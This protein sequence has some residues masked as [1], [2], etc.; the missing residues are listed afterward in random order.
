[1]ALLKHF[2]CLD[3]KYLVYNLVRRNLKIK[4]R[5]SWLG[6]L[7][8]LIPPAFSAIIYHFIFTEVMKVKMDHYL[9]FVIAGIVP[10]GVFTVCLQAGLESIPLNQNLINKVPLPVQ[11][12]PFTEALYGWIT[13]IASIPVIFVVAYVDG[14][15]PGPTWLALLP[16]WGLFFVISYSL[17]LIL[18]ILIVYL[19]DL[20][21]VLSLTLQVWFYATPILYSKEMV[22]ERFQWIITL[23]PLGALFTSFHEVLV[24]HRWPS[25]ELLGN[26]IAWS[27]G[28]FLCAFVLWLKLKDRIAEDL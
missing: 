28:I 2:F 9:L 7:W 6:I 18:G 14:V 22:P 11:S 23:N 21:Q 26:S 20:R 4:Y 10:W 8:T 27:A 16:L 25:A 3:R 12:L 19:K 24:H 5:N 13:L 1:M 17:A 15:P